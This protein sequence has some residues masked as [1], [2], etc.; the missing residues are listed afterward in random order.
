MYEF[1]KGVKIENHVFF[2]VVFLRG[3]GLTKLIKKLKIFK[4]GECAV[5]FLGL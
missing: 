3:E 2:E 5:G 1:L 4:S